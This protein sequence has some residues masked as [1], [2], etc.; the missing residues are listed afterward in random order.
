M[1]VKVGYSGLVIAAIVFGV[2]VDVRGDVEYPNMKR[3][4]KEGV[5][6]G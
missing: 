5:V 3:Q 1:E 6:S 2:I 4:G